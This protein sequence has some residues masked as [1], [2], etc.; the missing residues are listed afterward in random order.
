MCS[1]RE[2][3][4]GDRPKYS[5]IHFNC[6]NSAPTQTYLRKPTFFRQ[7]KPITVVIESRPPLFDCPLDVFL[8]V[9]A[10]LPQA[11]RFAG[12]ACTIEIFARIFRRRSCLNRANADAMRSS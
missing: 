7:R 9:S 10:E 8:R 1:G 3:A 5:F 11:S 6:P 2:A 12:A 4:H